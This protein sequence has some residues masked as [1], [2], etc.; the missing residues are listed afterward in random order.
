[1]SDAPPANT[2][3]APSARAVIGDD[4]ALRA[5]Y[6][7]CRRRTREQD[8]AEYALI[9]LLPAALRPACWALWAAANALDDLGDDRTAP[10]A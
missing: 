2:R 5:A 3:R 10:A 4:P 6:G 8:P 1:M 7:L 9:E